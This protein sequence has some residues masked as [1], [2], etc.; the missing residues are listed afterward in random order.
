MSDF[1]N[2][3]MPKLIKHYEENGN[4]KIPFDKVKIRNLARDD[5]PG[6]ATQ[7]WDE[8]YLQNEKDALVKKRLNTGTKW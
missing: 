7:G 2:N 6:F 4:R 3:I 5:P 1:E 8:I